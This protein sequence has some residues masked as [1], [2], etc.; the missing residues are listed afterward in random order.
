MCVYVCAHGDICV[1]YVFECM[2]SICIYGVY[3][4]V[5]CMCVCVCI[6]IVCKVS[7]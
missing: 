5:V 3:V 1:G 7:V 2:C 6:Y 4:C